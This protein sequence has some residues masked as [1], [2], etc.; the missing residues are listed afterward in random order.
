MRRALAFAFVLGG[1]ASA[2]D[3]VVTSHEGS[4]VTIAQRRPCGL[5]RGCTDDGV[6]T[7]DGSSWHFKPMADDYLDLILRL[8]PHADRAVL[9]GLLELAV[10]ALA[11]SGVGATLVS[12]AVAGVVSRFP[13]GPETR[14]LSYASTMRR[15][16]GC[17]TMSSPDN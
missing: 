10:H 9:A 16:S 11:A 2:G 15:T 4:M 5:L 8:A 12:T 13:A 1:C 17:R 6:V 14:S 7:W 3:Q